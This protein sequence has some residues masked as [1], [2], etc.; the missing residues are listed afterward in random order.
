MKLRS[1]PEFLMYC[2]AQTSCAAN[3]FE[4]SL[5]WATLWVP[6][7]TRSKSPEGNV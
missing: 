4:L 5:D 3:M 2:A 1:V 7:L 6:L